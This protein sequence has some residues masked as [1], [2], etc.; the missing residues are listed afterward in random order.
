MAV[1][2]F[3]DFFFLLFDQVNREQCMD[4]TDSQ[5][6]LFSHFFI[7]NG[8][9]DTIYTFKNYFATV[10]SIFSFSKISSIQTNSKF[11]KFITNERLNFYIETIT[12]TS[13][14]LRNFTSDYNNT[15]LGKGVY[16]T[17]LLWSMR[18]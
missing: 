18:L 1:F 17:T 12:T 7:K 6:S 10:F 4:T 15:F 2:T 5:I 16:S 3:F 9:Q 11:N 14:F 13:T 8:S